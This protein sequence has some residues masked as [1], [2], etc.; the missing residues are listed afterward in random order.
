MAIKLR[1][2]ARGRSQWPNGERLGIVKAV[3]P[4]EDK[5]RTEIIFDCL[6]GPDEADLDFPVFPVR[7]EL[8]G[9]P[10]GDLGELLKAMGEPA[11]AD[12][13]EALPDTVMMI[14]TVVETWKN[15]KS[16]DIRRFGKT[17]SRT[18]VAAFGPVDSDEALE[19]AA[20]MT[21]QEVIDRFNDQPFE[22]KSTAD[23]A[24]KA[25]RAA[26]AEDAGEGPEQD[27]PPADEEPPPFNDEP[28]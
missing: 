7:R 16:A 12:P 2:R 8:P 5:N 10:D 21:K 26:Q 27:G 28:F 3:V 20:G 1:R 22:L 19:K 25:W 18:E 4:Y 6:R 17:G 13:V 14:E 11:D 9:D 24:L 15:T 23:A